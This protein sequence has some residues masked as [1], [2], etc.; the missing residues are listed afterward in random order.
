MS[1]QSIVNCKAGG[2]CNG[3]N[4]G[5]V[6]KYAHKNGLSH[7]SCEQYTAYNLQDHKC[8]AIDVCR[9][10][11]PPAD[12]MH[13]TLDDCTAVEDTK[14]YI[15]DYYHVRGADQMKAELYA[16]GPISCG[17]HATDAFELYTG[18]I[19][20]EE[21]RFPKINHEISVVGYGHDDET[22]Q[23]YWIGRN[24]WG[25]YWGE[26]GFF[27]MIMGGNGLGIESDCLAGIPSYIKP[28]AT[29][30]AFIN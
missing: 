25:S 20:S 21:V 26:Y 17:I 27:Q 5:G 3:G 16:H 7:S 22:G 4:P 10:C 12:H 13:A 6:Y 19:Y 18:G 2:S 28:E 15:S 24:S 11:S 14:Y 29:V 1:A 8:E 30:E 9:D 23:D